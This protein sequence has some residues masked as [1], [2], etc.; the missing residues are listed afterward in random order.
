MRT[1]RQLH[2]KPLFRVRLEQ[3]LAMNRARPITCEQARSEVQARI[4]AGR[5]QF[6]M[7]VDSFGKGGKKG[8]KGKGHGKSG[9][10]EGQP[11]NQNPNPSKDVVCWHC[12]KRGHLSTECWSNPKNQSGSGG[13]QNN[14]GKGKPKNVTGKG[15]SSLEQGEQAVVVEPQPQPALASSLDL[16]SIETLVRSPHLYHEGW[17]RWTYDT[18]A[19]IS[20]FPLNARIGTETQAN[21]CSCKTASG[22]L[23]SDRG[24]LRVQ[25]TTEHGYG[26]IFQGRKADVDKNLISASKVHSKDHVAVVD[27]NGGY[28]FPCNSTLARKIQQL[29]Q[30]ETVKEP[31]AIRLY[32][33]HQHPAPGEH[34][35]E[36][37]IV[38]DACET[39][40]GAPSA[41]SKGARPM[42]NVGKVHSSPP[43]Q[44]P[45]TKLQIMPIE[46]EIV[47]E[48]IDDEAIEVQRPNVVVVGRG[49]TKL[50]VEHHVASGHAQH[51]TWCDA[52]MRARGIAG[53]HERREPGR[54]RGP[55]CSNW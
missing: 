6:P 42:A 1:S 38:L 2:L 51:R 20:A 30:K 35:K 46:S 13:T 21:D 53:R 15:A 26:V 40:V 39:T 18:G 19:A 49:P 55:T 29:V 36:S 3:H 8:K 32:R 12:G 43:A 45:E 50:E 17:L 27:S 47:D 31:G 5:S 16:A 23:I 25:G 7:E 22:E 28:I 11:R 34:T 9:K 41:L 14:G 44:S 4:E 48:G 33:V 37:R 10:K 54:G 24:G 52:C